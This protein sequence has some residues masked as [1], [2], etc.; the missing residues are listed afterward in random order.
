[1]ALADKLGAVNIKKSC[2]K[3]LADNFDLFSQMSGQ[4][5]MSGFLEHID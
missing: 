2:L 1:M 3:F 4:S 5:S